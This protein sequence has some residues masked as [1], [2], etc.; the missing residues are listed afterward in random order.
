[1]YTNIQDLRNKVS[2]A[3]LQLGLGTSENAA[4]N[5]F[6]FIMGSTP[7]FNRHTA[8]SEILIQLLGNIEMPAVVVRKEEGTVLLAEV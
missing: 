8:C 3:S 7:S 4:G 5:S 1:M 2:C 6:Q